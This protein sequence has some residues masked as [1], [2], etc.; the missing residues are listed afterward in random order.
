MKDFWK[1][2]WK[3]LVI[4][5]II[6]ICSGISASYFAARAM[7]KQKIEDAAPIEY[8]D[9]KVEEVITHS[10]NEDE[11]IVALIDK[12]ADKDVVDIILE[13]VKENNRILK[14]K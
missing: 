6:I 7:D 14:E 2:F 9:K 12:K 1:D 4:G 5:V 3:Q 13:I 11:K 10:D 8:V